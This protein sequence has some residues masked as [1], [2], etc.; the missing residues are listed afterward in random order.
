MRSLRRWN[1][2]GGLI[3][4]TRPP[5]NRDR[6]EHLR[7]WA[8]GR[9]HGIG[10]R[11]GWKQAR[12]AAIGANLLRFIAHASVCKGPPPA[13]SVGWSVVCRLAIAAD[14]G[15]VEARLQGAKGGG[16]LVFAHASASLSG[17]AR[18]PT[19]APRLAP[20][21]P[22]LRASPSS[23]TRL[24]RSLSRLPRR[25]RPLPCRGGGP[26]TLITSWIELRFI[27][28]AASPR[29]PAPVK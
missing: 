16:A 28:L 23:L 20:A 6:D 5:G 10:T 11:G 7:N 26:S 13:R 2:G 12:G 18:R 17:A 3:G 15:A 8:R 25:A 29:L 4:A 21:L 19:T 14:G 9:A 27:S 22:V 24:H 1:S